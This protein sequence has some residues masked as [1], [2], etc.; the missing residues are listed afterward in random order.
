MGA[1][2][3]APWLPL[4]SRPPHDPRTLPLNGLAGWHLA[5]RDGIDI[6]P[7]G[8]LRLARQPGVQR[9]L[10]EAS[11]AFGG[12]QLPRHLAYTSDC[13]I[14]LLDSANARLKKFDP[15][16][17]RFDNVPCTGGVGAGPR[18]F[19]A[20]SA[21]AVCGDNLLVADTGNHRLVV[22]SLLGFLV[23][24]FWA[25]PPDELAQPWSPVDVCVSSDR[26]VLVADPANGCVHQFNFAGRWLG[27]IAGV[28]AVQALAI[29]VDNRLY[30]LID[31]LLPVQVLQLPG[32]EALGEVHSV[33]SVCARFAAPYFAVDAAGNVD[34]GWLCARYNPL[35]E[36][37]GQ[38]RWFDA[39]GRPVPAA[40]PQTSRFLAS[41]TA[42]SEALDSRLYRCQWDRIALRLVVPEG[43]RVRVSSYSAETELTTAQLVA[44]DDA[45]WATRQWVFPPEGQ[46]GAALDWDC[47][48]RSLPGRFLWLRI[49]MHSDTTTT[50]V[51]CSAALDFP[52]IS[53][54]RYLPAVF[55]EEP[56]SA[57]FTDRFL[58]IFDRG[59]RQLEAHID[60][61]GALLDPLSAPA[62][63]GRSD[64]LS[65][66]ASWVGVT[67]D[68][69]LPLATRRR[70]VKQ[71]GHLYQCRGTLAGLRHMLD[72][73]LGFSSR[74]C[75]QAPTCRPCPDQHNVTWEPPGLLLEHFVLR[76]WLFV[77]CGRLGEQARL[78]GQKIVNRSQLRGDSGDGNAQLE[79]TQLNAIQDPLRD[80]FHVYAHRFSVFLPAWV[81]R[82]QGFRR[83][84][85]RLVEAEKPA[86]TAADIIYVEP[87]FRIGIQSMIGYDS[88][89][90]CYPR[91]VTL[92]TAELGKA[93]VLGEQ[94]DADSTLRVGEKARIG[95][96]TRLR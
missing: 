69:Q 52:R 85:A 8:D 66:L 15:C 10:G 78:W 28:G 59:F 31:P 60:G 47:L 81:G 2:S 3:N 64:F 17:C 49:E 61:M 93:S 48:L 63:A 34:L 42:F 23:R 73:Y 19:D 38:S 67:L 95:T 83:S 20:P 18:Q 71:A 46:D 30:L 16:A 1:H 75:V 45:Q 89:I 44:L 68:R 12:L 53:L 58:G 94:D 25:P 50:P 26:R 13:G 70:L 29:D 90:G 80:P 9:E 84:I 32:G 77:G 5:Q 22:Y 65:W 87:R 92:G 41:G 96:T 56:L 86:H 33:D 79:V 24:G 37:A 51:V 76:R 91:G 72:L 62:E 55:A 74:Q 88:V 39:A 27:A 54:A 36:A 40:E 43:T 21:I 7:C 6:S 14:L 11:G 35:G 4:T 82:L 57:D